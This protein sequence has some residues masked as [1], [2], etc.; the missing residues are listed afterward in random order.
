MNGVA[1]KYG[2]VAPEAK[3]NFVPSTED[4]ADF[5]DLSQLQQY[6][7]DFLNYGNPCEL[8]SVVLDG[9]ALTFPSAPADA[10][11]G[12][13]SEQISNEDGT[14][15]APITLVLTSEGQYSSQGLTLTFDT[16][17]NIYATSINITWYRDLEILDSVDFAP[18]SAFYFCQNQIQNYNKVKIT[19]NSI[20]MPYN[21]LKLRVIDYGYGTYFYGDELRNVKCIQEI[22]P[23]STEISINTCDFTLDSKSDIVYSFQAKQPLSVYFNDNLIATTFVKSAKRKA[24]KLWEVQ[25]E[26]YISLLD[27]ISFVGGMYTDKNAVEL[28]TEI[29]TAAKVPY[30]ISDVFAEK[31]VTG[32]I[33]Y[34]TCREALMQ[35]AFAVGA[36]VDTS[37]SDKIKV[38]E[39]S[40]EVTQTIPL[41]RIMQGQSFEDNETVTAVE[42]DYYAYKAISEN[43]TVY[44]ASESG[45]G[46]NILVKFSEPLHDLEI[47]NGEI[48]SFGTNHAI[49]TANENCVLTG[50]QYEQTTTTKRK[51]NPVVLASEIDNTKA[52]SGATLVSASNVGDV[53]E[54]CYSYLVNTSQTNLK[55]V[56]GKH[57]ST[58]GIVKY[59]QAKYGTFKYGSTASDLKVVTYEQVVNVGDSITAETAYL[60]DVTGRII[61]ETFNLNGGI[62]IKEAVLK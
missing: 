35:V 58:G 29:F 14:F 27:N 31:T 41:S 20:N 33:G 32:H 47:V 2:D 57:I 23:I 60:G 49:I 12:L 10:N 16:Y 45:T 36:V 4:K 44:E 15:T 48:L 30:D 52:I 3:E 25:S 17:N 38:F 56:E 11:L 18:T 21:R 8:Y 6:N 54:R 62:I 7:V 24:E 37:N 9:N 39:L 50:C 61:K 19:F 13:W 40:G 42:L 5:V 51:T 26:D 55:I 1:I 53:L 34:T 22:C 43:V 46:E 59:G 28:L